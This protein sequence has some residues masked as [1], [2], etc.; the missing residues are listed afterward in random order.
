MAEHGDLGVAIKT[1]IVSSCATKILWKLSEFWVC[2]RKNDLLCI[3]K[4]I[5]TISCVSVS[6]QTMILMVL[7]YCVNC[8]LRLVSFLVCG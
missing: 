4:Y 1:E 2:S 3:Y 8:V 6:N 7:I 5:S